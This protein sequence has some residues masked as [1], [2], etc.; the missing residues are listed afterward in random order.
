MPVFLVSNEIKGSVERL[1][2]SRAHA[3]MVDFLIF[4]RA[5]KLMADD[6]AVEGRSAIALSTSNQQYMQA[7]KDLMEWPVAE[8]DPAEKPL[9]YYNPFGTGGHETRGY[10]SP[11]YPSNGPS[12]TARGSGFA[13]ITTL[14][15]TNPAVLTFKPNYERE[16]PSIVLKAGAALPMLADVAIWY[17]RAKDLAEFTNATPAETFTGLMSK[18]TAALGLTPVVVSLLF[19]LTVPEH[20][21]D[22]E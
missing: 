3:R 12:V 19:D 18:T 9:P 22:A 17:H 2:S 7:I 8:M 5:L 13:K 11:K 6:Q 14:T 10:R 4:R 16:L 20:G 21:A 15:G 1:R